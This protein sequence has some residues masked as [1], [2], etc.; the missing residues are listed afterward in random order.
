M[1]KHNQNNKSNK[2]TENEETIENKQ[3]TNEERGK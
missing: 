1:T 3:G 2:H